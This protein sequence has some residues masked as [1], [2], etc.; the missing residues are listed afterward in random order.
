M[1]IRKVAVIG[2]G[3]MGASIAVALVN[4]GFQVLLKDVN[5]EALDGG[6]A[7]IDRMLASLVKKGLPQQEADQRKALIRTVENFKDLADVDLAIEAVLEK[8]EIKTAVF[9]ELER[10][11]KEETIFAT[12][13]SSLSIT[14]IASH[15]KRPERM[16]GL[17]FFN[18]AHLMKLVEVIPGFDTSDETVS[19][20][21]RFAQSLD[22]LAVRV[23]E[24]ASFLVNRLLGRYMTEALWCLEE[25]SAGIE[26]ID[27]AAVDFAMPIGPLA[28]RDM[29]GADIGLAVARF[30]HQE[31]GERFK[32]AQILVEMVSRNWLGQKTGRGFYVY[33]PETRKRT[34]VNAELEQLVKD[35]AVSQSKKFTPERLFLPMINEAFLALQE[36]VCSLDDLD[37]AL[38]AGLGMRM[39]PLAIAEEMGLAEC[40]SELESHFN[41]YGER[42][43]PAPLLKRY[44]RAGRKKLDRRRTSDTKQVLL[45]K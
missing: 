7:K 38:M 19:R 42:F 8:M 44:V 21:I 33:D 18:P 45:S 2:A 15:L 25:A 3:T 24:C 30:N 41:L 12:N 43:R 40:L 17:H 4:S 27:K 5:Q 14:E 23:E 31:Y 32:P 6:I 9:Q 34:S 22:K 26:E 36:H 37:P 39:G 13:T 28:L 1:D 10:H 35:N 29:N 20:S 16:I 11:C